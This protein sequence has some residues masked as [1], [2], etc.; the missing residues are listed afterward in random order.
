MDEVG[1]EAMELCQENLCTR[2]AA[3]LPV[4]LPVKESGLLLRY[5]VPV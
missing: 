5:I 4:P 1:I 3:R 2:G